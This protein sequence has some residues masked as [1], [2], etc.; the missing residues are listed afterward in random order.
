MPIDQSL[1]IDYTHDEKFTTKLVE[2]FMFGSSMLVAAINSWQP[3]QKVYLP[4][5]DWYELFNDKY[6]AGSN[7]LLIET[8]CRG[9]TIFVK[10]GAIFH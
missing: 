9:D 8:L 2:S 1:A 6:H 3:I 7:A 5:G 10:A 4:A